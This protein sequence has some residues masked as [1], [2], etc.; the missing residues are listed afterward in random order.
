MTVHSETSGAVC[1][2]CGQH[3]CPCPICHGDPVHFY[4]QFQSGLP[5]EGCES[6]TCDQCGAVFI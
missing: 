1:A 6:E 3:P 5:E 4:G 2:V